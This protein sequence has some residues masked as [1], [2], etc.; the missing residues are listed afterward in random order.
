MRQ[1]VLGKTTKLTTAAINALAD[2]EVA[3]Y[4]LQSGKPSQLTYANSVTGNIK[5]IGCI[6]VGT[7]IGSIT[8]PIHGNAF[9][10]TK[11][12]YVA[13]TKFSQKITVVKRGIVGDYTVI[14][15]KKGQPCNERYKWTASYH[16]FDPDMTADNIAA[17][18]AQ[19]INTSCA[20]AG[21]TATVNA[22][23][24]TVNATESGVDYS[25]TL[26]D[27]ANMSTL[28]ALTAGTKALFDAE[29]IKDMYIKAAADAGVEYT[30]Q[31][32]TSLVYP[33]YPLR[34]DA[35]IAASYN[36]YTL[37]FAEPRAVGTTDK[38][39]HQVVQLAFPTTETTTGLEAILNAIG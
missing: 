13:A 18:L 22:N 7:K 2:G 11:G 36:V 15:A 6:A 17:K 4:D 9:S 29:A 33:N 14:V 23:V 37:K 34:Q 3:F 1:F 10:W 32:G 19:K 8:I 12:S 26:A 25:I 21:V 5:S 35:A 16:V 27:N 24:I 20:G 39:V 30:Y 28:S 31:D 38:V